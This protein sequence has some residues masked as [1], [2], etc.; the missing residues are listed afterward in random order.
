MAGR[1]PAPTS[2]SSRSRQGDRLAEALQE[3]AEDPRGRSPDQLALDLV[4]RGVDGDAAADQAA[5]LVALAQQLEREGEDG[6]DLGRVGL[7]AQL[8]RVRRQADEG[9]DPVAGDEGRD[10]RQGAD[11]L[12]R[13]G[14]E[15]DLLLGLAQR[16]RRQVGVARRPGGRRG[17]RSRRRGGAGRRGAR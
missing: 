3:V 4:G 16:R 8:G 10:R 5:H 6:L 13:G 14:V 11:Q 7:E 15:G 17:R 2:A 12:D 9:V 1:S